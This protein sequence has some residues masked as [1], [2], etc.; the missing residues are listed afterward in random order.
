MNRWEEI[1]HEINNVHIPGQ[2]EHTS[3]PRWA[4]LGIAAKR[5]A[6]LEEINAEL[7]ESNLKLSRNLTTED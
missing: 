6:E 1:R 5:I 2:S 7:A 4:Q 3:D